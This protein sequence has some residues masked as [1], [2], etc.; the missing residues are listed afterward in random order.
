MAITP[1]PKC[2]TLTKEGG[3]R[4]W[5]ILLSILIF[6]IGLVFLLAGKQP[7][8]CLGCGTTGNIDKTNLKRLFK[9][10]P[11]ICNYSFKNYPIIESY[12]IIF[13]YF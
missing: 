12:S 8:T 4:G 1:C 5:Q 6:P 11:L 7:S 2:S 13:L 10:K 9:N 3:F